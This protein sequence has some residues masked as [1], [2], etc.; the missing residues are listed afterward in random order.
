MKATLTTLCGCKR[1]MSITYPPTREI[2]VPLRE[3]RL[4]LWFQ[5]DIAPSRLNLRVRRFE[6]RRFHGGPYGE[7][8]Y[9]ERT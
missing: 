9:V 4:S 5:E 8:E 3:D 7:A 2:V 1:E 6:L